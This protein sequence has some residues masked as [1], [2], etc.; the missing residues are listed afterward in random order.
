MSKENEEA[1]IT[2]A[3]ETK[4]Y[5]TVRMPSDLRDRLNQTAKR[6]KRSTG[7]L[8]IWLLDKVDLEGLQG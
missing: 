5:F 3:L 7:N 1:E 2:E 6:L 4:G 8:V